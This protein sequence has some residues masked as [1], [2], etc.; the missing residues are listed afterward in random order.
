MDL[1]QLVLSFCGFV[2]ELFPPYM[3][4]C[5]FFGSD[6]LGGFGTKAHEGE[7]GTGKATA[8]SHLLTRPGHSLEQPQ[9]DARRS[10]CIV[11][12]R[13][14]LT[15]QIQALPHNHMDTLAEWLR[16]CPAKAL[17]SVMLW[18]RERDW[19]CSNEWLSSS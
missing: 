3:T 16:R 18:R 9:K 14:T 4:G 2:I 6:T 1:Q 7:F 11:A 17:G 5:F 10:M 8:L 13:P 12:Q 19:M 15:H